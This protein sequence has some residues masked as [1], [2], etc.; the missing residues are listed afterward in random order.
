MKEFLLFFCCWSRFSFSP[1][2]SCF[3][4]PAFCGRSLASHFSWAVSEEKNTSL[5]KYIF[6][7]GGDES[8]C[9]CERL[10]KKVVIIKYSAASFFCLVAFLVCVCVCVKDLL[11]SFVRACDLS[12]QSTLLNDRYLGGVV[13]I[14]KK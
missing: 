7:K 1:I 3:S 6:F 12:H 14:N 9:V 5:K 2:V 11:F 13:K 10:P 8:V 4:L